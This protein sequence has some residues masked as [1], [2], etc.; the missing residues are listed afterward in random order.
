V[1]PILDLL[2]Q[3]I[4]P[5]K[6]ALSIALGVVLGVFPMLGTTTLLCAGVAIVLR[7]NLPAIQLVNFLIYPMQLIL[8]LPLLRAGS[9]IAKA[10]PVTMSLKQIFA[11]MQS[12]LW[13]LI[14]ILGSATMGAVAI[15]LVLAPIAAV[16]IYFTLAPILRRANRVI[17]KSGGLPA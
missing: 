10:A 14:K 5:E 8:F 3:G 4:T 1:V 9:R 12:D 2:R 7:L 17:H 16:V 11:M 6:V 15:W 13:G